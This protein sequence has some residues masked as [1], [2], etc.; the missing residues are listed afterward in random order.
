[1]LLG[2]PKWF[3][4]TQQQ[5]QVCIW[6]L[7]HFPYKCWNA[8]SSHSST[9]NKTHNNEDRGP[10]T[11]PVN[12]NVGQSCML[13]IQTTK[14][15]KNKTKQQGGRMAVWWKHSTWV[16]Q[17]VDSNPNSGSDLLPFSA[18][19]AKSTGNS[20]LHYSDCLCVPMPL[21]LF[22][23]SV[24]SHAT[25]IILIVCVF[26]CHWHYSDCLCVPMPLTL[27]TDV[28]LIVCV[29]PCHWLLARPSPME[30]RTWDL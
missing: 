17:A 4:L 27:F 11:E 12:S 8:N 13:Q 26:P 18:S 24:C 29:F 28:I 7:Q 16:Q 5:L 15:S 3:L 14:H 20:H 2:A 21:A 25:G 30:R 9:E 22:W 19:S 6:Q 10:Y 23:L 1:M